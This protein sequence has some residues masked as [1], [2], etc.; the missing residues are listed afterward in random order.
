MRMT[1]F[2]TLPLIGM[3]L[4]ILFLCASPSRGFA[5]SNS[6]GSTNSTGNSSSSNGNT[7][8]AGGNSSSQDSSQ[9]SDSPAAKQLKDLKDKQQLLE[10]QLT[11]LTAQQKLIQ[12]M[13][14]A[15]KS[16]PPTPGIT[17]DAD[18]KI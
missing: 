13:V 5:Q 11:V 12:A 6:N 18:V 4:P 1:R 2:F 16:T 15:G 9:N 10:Q 7:N 17:T 14:P 8:S 3:A